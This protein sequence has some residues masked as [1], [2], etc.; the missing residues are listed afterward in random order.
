MEKVISFGVR[1]RDELVKGADFLAEG[2]VRTLGPYGE[3][4]YIDKGNRITND[5]VTAAGEI[6]NMGRR[7]ENN[8]HKPCSECGQQIGTHKRCLVCTILIH[9]EKYPCPRCPF[10]HT[11]SKDGKYC[12]SHDPLHVRP[13][14]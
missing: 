9:E 6:V 5:G 2:V 7:P 4:F 12:Q 3:N 14:W 10:Y 8:D 1:A 11:Y 13:V